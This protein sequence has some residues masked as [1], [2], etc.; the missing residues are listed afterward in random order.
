M[1]AAAVVPAAAPAAIVGAAAVRAAIAVGATVGAYREY[2]P[3]FFPLPHPS[4]RNLAWLKRNPWFE[5]QGV[6]ALRRR[7]KACIGQV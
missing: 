1:V 5:K 7:V 4:W 2:L 3:Q 6:P